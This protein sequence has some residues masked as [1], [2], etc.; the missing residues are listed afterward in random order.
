MTTI[1]GAREG[2]FYSLSKFTDSLLRAIWKCVYA[3]C[4][5]VEDIESE[6]VVRVLT[7]YG[8]RFHSDGFEIG[9]GGCGY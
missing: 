3:G 8:G 6:R 2:S 1:S 7:G 5:F 9:R 4:S